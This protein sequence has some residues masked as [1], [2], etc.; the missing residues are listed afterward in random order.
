[1]KHDKTFA[2][3]MEQLARRNSISSV[4]SDFLEISVC[5]LSMGA[6]EERY[7]EIMRRY[8]KPEAY[9]LAEAFGAL[10]LEMDNHGEGLKD[11][12]GDFFM[13]HISHGHNG[14]F[15][16]P[17]PVC[18]M[19]ARMSGE[20]KQGDRVLDCACG[21]GRILMA[22]ARINRFAYFYGADVD[23]NC[24]MMALINFCLNA[25]VGEVAWM[26]SLSNE[27]YGAW[28]I[29]I[30]PQHGIPYIKQITQ[31]D[32]VICLKLPETRNP[33]PVTIIP[34]ADFFDDLIGSSQGQQLTLF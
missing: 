6:M 3:Y 14:Q 25:M 1:M 30:H 31:E 22:A 18:D 15:F 5:A 26:N 28:Q 16:T 7:M 23:R 8:D 24:C 32:S 20:I 2:Q 11:V 33:Q 27:F 9:A 13:E 21:S 10:V 19:M 4:F 17:E 12:F 29:R 34:E